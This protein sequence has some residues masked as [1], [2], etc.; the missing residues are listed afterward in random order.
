[1]AS[2]VVSV[3]S[4]RG[5]RS[6]TV[7][8]WLGCAVLAALI[9]R[10]Y[11]RAV[12]N[13]SHFDAAHYHNLWPAK[14]WLV[15]H[16]GGGSLALLLG[17]LQFIGWIRR[18]YVKAHRWMGRLYLAG[19]VVGSIA[20]VYMGLVVAPKAFGVALLYLALAWVVTSGM[21]Y[22][23]VM[24]RQ[25]AA[26]REWMIRS[27]VVTFA[28]VL[29]RLGEDLNV[30]G[31]LGPSAQA[32]MLAWIAWAVPLLFTEVVLQWRRSVGVAKA[33]KG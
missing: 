9:V 5:G 3:G 21:A 12:M 11:G 25:F 28:F 13:Y 30:Y 4:R 8:V 6:R 2:S 33:G 18:K 23:S 1:M 19:V 26:H 24:R 17:P 31:S 7:L 27:Y 16:L 15:A 14:W 29:F 22:V 20:S 32:V 10:F